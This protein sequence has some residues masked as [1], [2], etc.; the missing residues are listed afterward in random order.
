MRRLALG[1]WVTAWAAVAVAQPARSLTVV[2]ES[3]GGPRPERADELMAATREG[4]A[5]PG[6][7]LGRELDA[8]V[9]ERLSYPAGR[10]DHPLLALVREQVGQAQEEA[11]RARFREA[12]Q[13]L[14]RLRGVVLQ[15]AAAEAADPRIRPHLHPGLVIMLKGLLRLGRQGDAESLAV[16]LDRSYPDLPV[17]EREHGPEVATFVKKVRAQRAAHAPLALSIESAPT[18]ASVFLDGRYVGTTPLRLPDVK[19]G[20]Y[21][22]LAH[23][24]EQHSRV[25]VVAIR[26][27]SVTV[28][29]DLAFDGALRAGGFQ[30][31][32]EAERRQ[33][34][35]EYALR[36]ARALGAAEVITM[37]L[38][39]SADRPLWGA[40]VYTVESG[41]VLRS[42]AVALGPVAPPRSLLVALGRFLRGAAPAEGL[43]VRDE[44]PGRTPLR[45]GG[46]SDAPPTREPGRS[47]AWQVV[48]Y[49]GM[50]L[51]LAGVALGAYWLAVNGKADCVLQPGQLQCPN[52]RHTLVPG[53]A[54]LS[55]GGALTI[56][57][58]ILLIVDLKRARVGVTAGSLRQPNGVW[59]SW[60]F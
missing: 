15:Q 10:A 48:A 44:R 7:V 32:S 35:A 25:H 42:A 2:C 45:G 40:T 4:L 18:G 55:A 38:G 13:R 59:V 12:V 47:R 53:A 6:V 34:E 22:V 33:L 49:V 9:T 36:L 43:I 39:G 57:S 16:E 5:L 3:H 37:G 28:R 58:G 24:G 26:E 23:A 20:R 14:E 29:L 56:G 27:E 21:R 41:G 52:A 11:A 51:G 30:F 50:A 19:P 1:L 54:T 31:Q 17:T 8:L 60:D 46:A